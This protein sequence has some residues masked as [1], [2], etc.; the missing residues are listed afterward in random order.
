MDV[1][2]TYSQQYLTLA[3]FL[4]VALVFPIAPIILAKLLAPQKPSFNKSQVYE[5]GT[6]LAGDPWGQFKIHYYVFALMFVVFDVEVVFL[7]PWAVVF[8]SAAFQGFMEM[9]VFL[10]ILGVG[11]IYAWR[12]KALEWE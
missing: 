4:M 2:L 8:K 11:L 6:L 9:V 12:K 10:G 3:I 7:Y 1:V 5:C